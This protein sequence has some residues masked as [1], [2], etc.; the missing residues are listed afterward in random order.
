[1]V[2]WQVKLTGPV[3]DMCLQHEKGTSKLEKG[4]IMPFHRVL[5]QKQPRKKLPIFRFTV[6]HYFVDSL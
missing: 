5:L 6:M 1:V 4:A 2:W 3:Q